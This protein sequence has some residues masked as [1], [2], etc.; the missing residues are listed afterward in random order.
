[1][2][3]SHH[4]IN[5]TNDINDNIVKSLTEKGVGIQRYSIKN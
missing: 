2:V 4:Y 3:I 1:M 5:F